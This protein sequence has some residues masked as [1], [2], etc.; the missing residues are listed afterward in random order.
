MKDY[1][2]SFNYTHKI[3]TEI[4]LKTFEQNLGEIKS[5]FGG[6][7]GS[8]TPCLRGANAAL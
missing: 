8:R 4:F 6:A 2:E 1:L 5:I 3:D 7:G